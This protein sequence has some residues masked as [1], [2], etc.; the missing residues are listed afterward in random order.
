MSIYLCLDVKCGSGLCFRSSLRFCPFSLRG[1]DRLEVRVSE[2]VSLQIGAHA[3][4]YKKKL[5][6]RELA[7]VASR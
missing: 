6:A 7:D 1:H 3:R 5:N 2:S 4:V